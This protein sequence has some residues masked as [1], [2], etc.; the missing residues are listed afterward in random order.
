MSRWKDRI[1]CVQVPL[2]PGYVFVRIA[3]RDRMRVLQP[4][5][6][7][8]LLGQ[9]N[10]PEALPEMEIEALRTAWR[11]K[12]LLSRILS[13]RLE[14]V[15]LITKGPFE[16]LEGVLLRKTSCGWS[17]LVSDLFFVCTRC[18]CS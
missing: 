8:R 4:P 2:F 13:C 9:D 1:T 15:C 5:G 17:C 7:V 6:V 3:L 12:S 18:R 10:R 11:R 14:K 16:G